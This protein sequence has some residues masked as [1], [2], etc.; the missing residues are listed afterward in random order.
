LRQNSEIV[1]R[2]ATLEDAKDLFDWRNH[3]LTREMS[4]TSDVISWESH[5][6]WLKASLK[7]E[8]RKIYIFG[9][10]DQTIG[11]GRIDCHHKISELSWVINPEYRG[12]GYGTGLVC[13]LFD[14]SSPPR[15][16]II[17]ASNAA[18][19][20]IAEKAGFLFDKQDGDILTFIG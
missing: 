9:H 16:A 1:K 6:E 20:A 17:K 3:A 11:M 12:Q 5:L 2:E 4:I 13:K 10:G 18:S 15:R 14:E 8:S 19:I 7:M